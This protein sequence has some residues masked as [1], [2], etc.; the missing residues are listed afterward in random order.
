MQI[1]NQIHNCTNIIESTWD[2]IKDSMGSSC[3]YSPF[4]KINT[5]NGSTTIP[6]EIAKTFN[7]FFVHIAKNLD[8]KRI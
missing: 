2:I 3:S 4:T 1:K 6:D 5:D 8:N 7:E